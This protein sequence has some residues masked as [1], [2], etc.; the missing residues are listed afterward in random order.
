MEALR[1]L[2]DSPFKPTACRDCR[3]HLLAPISPR[4]ANTILGVLVVAFI[5][6][7]SAGPAH[8]QTLD[9]AVS[10]LVTS[11]C[12]TSTTFGPNLTRICQQLN[13]GGGQGGGQGGVAQVSTAASVAGVTGVREGETQRRALDRL[14]ER[15]EASAGDSDWLQGR[16]GSFVSGEY[17]RFDK[18]VTRFEPGFDSD[19]WAGTVG[20]DY[21]IT[22]NL[23]V[24]LAGSYRHADGRFDGGGDFDIDTYRGILYASILPL[25]K[26][27]IDLVAS[28]GHQD[29]SVTRRVNFLP[30]VGG[31]SGT[32]VTGDATGN[33]D[34]HEY[35]VS[36]NI[37]YDLAFGR[38][39]VGP[40]AGF[41][42]KETVLDGFREHGTTGLELVYD[43]QVATSLTGHVGL[44]GSVAIA[45]P[46]GPVLPQVAFDY[47]HEFERDQRAIYA[48][49]VEDTTATRFRFQNDPPDRNYFFAGAGVVMILP[50]GLSPF[51]NYRALVGY[52]DRS[53]HTVTAGIRFTF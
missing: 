30:V 24:G 15:R 8:A 47:V 1:V 14:K 5:I 48:R 26:L 27:F 46:I 44:F 3:A 35:S 10:S 53:S 52:E 23:L 17:E 9:E 51:L 4:E 37:G 34:G 11:L 7:F 29:Y 40:R 50:S 19:T 33:T 38:F 45:T 25:P 36:T 49:L 22:K 32:L 2:S 43:R 31:V 21:F 41:E 16:F 28:Y 6:S 39:T 42:Y 20:A 18:D 12:G 13:A